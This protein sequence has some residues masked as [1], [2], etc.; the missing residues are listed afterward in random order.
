MVYLIV[1]SCSLIGTDNVHVA[2]HRISQ[3]AQGDPELALELQKALDLCDGDQPQKLF[4]LFVVD[5]DALE[6]ILRHQPQKTC[7]ILVVR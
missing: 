6:F 5:V 4:G 1:L 2:S 7:E 3:V